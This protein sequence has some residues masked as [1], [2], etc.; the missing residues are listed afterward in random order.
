M[1]LQQF[2]K[3]LGAAADEFQATELDANQ[4]YMWAILRMNRM[5]SLPINLS[6]TLDDLGESASSRITGF[7]KTMQK[8]MD[9]GREILALTTVYEWLKAGHTVGQEQL[10][11]LVERLQ[12]ATDR[13]KV[14]LPVLQKAA[15]GVD[16]CRQ[17]A[18]VA[19]ADWLGDIDVYCRSEALKFGIPHEAVRNVI[20]GSNFTK[21]NPDGSVT[22][23]E[24]G[25]VQKGPR[26]IAPEETIHALLFDTE[27]LTA[28][29]LAAQAVM[30]NLN[31]V[32]A[33][34]LF[35]PISYVHFA[36]SRVESEAA[37]EAEEADEADTSDGEDADDEVGEEVPE[38]YTGRPLNGH[39]SD[40]FGE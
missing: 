1:D 33:P 21:L 10:A 6:P 7:L 27:E 37:E 12:I 19:I 2:N 25:K 35:D 34:T 16:A 14:L 23:D 30:N 36:Q 17:E 15:Q 4:Y 26:F 5:Y 38:S 9:E 39:G 40:M 3:V 22:K 24:N 28:E 20:M 31:T 8:E 29:L 11:A 13:Q 18:L 32:A